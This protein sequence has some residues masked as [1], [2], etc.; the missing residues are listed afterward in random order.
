MTIPPILA[1]LVEGSRRRASGGPKR[2]DEPAEDSY[3]WY[4][5]RVNWLGCGFAQG[6]AVERASELILDELL[7]DQCILGRINIG[8]HAP[9]ECR[10]KCFIR[11]HLGACDLRLA[12][13]RVHER[14]LLVLSPLGG[15]RTRG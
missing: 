2:C 9:M 4:D 1:E 3:A 14:L 6:A 10:N 5:N 8:P 12:E 11:R 15:A 13:Q 7:E